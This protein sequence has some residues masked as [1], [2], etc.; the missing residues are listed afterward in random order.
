[1]KFNPNER[2]RRTQTNTQMSKYWL[3]KFREKKIGEKLVKFE[4]EIFISKKSY[5]LCGSHVIGKFENVNDF[6][7]TS[8]A[9]EN[10]AIYQG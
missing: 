4:K 5:C 7:K 8:G 6:I 2:Q 3:K 10:S 1:M 9:T